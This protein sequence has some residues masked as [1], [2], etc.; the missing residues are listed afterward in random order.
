MEGTNSSQNNNNNTEGSRANESNII[1]RR[2]PFSPFIAFRDLSPSRNNNERGGGGGGLFGESG[3]FGR[4]SL[5]IISTYSNYG[6]NS[7]Y[8]PQPTLNSDEI[9]E[10]IAQNLLEVQNMID[11]GNYKEYNDSEFNEENNNMDEE[12]DEKNINTDKKEEKNDEKKDDKNEEKNE[13][14]INCFKPFRYHTR[15]STLTNYHSPFPNKKP[16]MGVTLLSFENLNRNSC[17]HPSNLTQQRNRNSSVISTSPLNSQ[18]NNNAN[19]EN[20]SSSITMNR[21]IQTNNENEISNNNIANNNSNLNSNNNNSNDNNRNEN[22]TTNRLNINSFVSS[23]G[24]RSQGRYAEPPPPV[25]SP[26]HQ[27]PD[28]E[29]HIVKNLGGD[30][31]LGI[32]REFDQINKVIGSLSSELLNEHNNNT[33]ILT[34]NKLSEIQNKSYYNL[35]RLIPILDRTGRIYSDIST[36]IEHSMKTN[37]LELLSKNLFADVGRINED[38]KYF[39]ADERRRVSQD[40]LSHNTRRENRS[41]T[42]NF[43]PP[44]NKFETKLINSIPIIDT[45]Y[46]TGRND[47]QISPILDIFIQNNNNNNEEETGSMA[48]E[49]NINNGRNSDNNNTNENRNNSF[50]RNINV[51]SFHIEFKAENNNNDKNDKNDDDEEKSIK[52]GNKI[53]KNKNGL[54]MLGIKTRR[55]KS[56][57]KNG[58]KSQSNSK[59]EDKKTKKKK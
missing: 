11:Y 18:N 27:E 48:E 51:D 55:N 14:K 36:F 34:P 1:F 5:R 32:F 57:K 35:K 28:P 26:K 22:E 15:Q 31:F 47:T 56:K 33:E 2:S 6:R 29:N 24:R 46:M 8:A 59:D 39:S 42:V 20:S 54:K 4:S 44:V 30:G 43:V 52:N 25:P 49:N 40:I 16:D 37:Q 12:E 13:E 7:E 23:L 19:N 58:E 21:G 50:V 45:P 53:K 9:R 3:F 38:L 10:T 17:V 41:G